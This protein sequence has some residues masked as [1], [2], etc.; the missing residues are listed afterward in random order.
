LL[1]ARLMLG[2]VLVFHGAQKLFGVFGGYGIEGTAGYFASLG[3]PAPTLAVVLA[4]SAEFFG[5]L[6]VAA[7]LIFRPAL[8]PIVATMLVASFTAHTGFDITQGGREYTLTLAAMSA[9]LFLLGPGRLTVGALVATRS[10]ATVRGAF[11]ARA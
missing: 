2:T 11:E 5:G 9:A 3:I 6:A 8:V 4:G 7:G 1:I 10:D